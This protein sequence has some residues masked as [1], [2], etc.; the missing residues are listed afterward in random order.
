MIGQNQKSPESSRMRNV[1][2]GMV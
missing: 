2:E 1:E